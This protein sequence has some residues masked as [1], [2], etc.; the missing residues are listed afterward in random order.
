MGG[1]L[2]SLAKTD[3]IP[4]LIYGT[5][6]PSPAKEEK[7]SVRRHEKTGAG[8]RGWRKF[9]YIWM[10]YTWTRKHSPLKITTLS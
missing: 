3:Q 10:R 1:V 5:K 2:K 6:I 7:R 9:R 4:V 8:P